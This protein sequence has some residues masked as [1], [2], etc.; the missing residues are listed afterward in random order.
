MFILY[1]KLRYNIYQIKI[2]LSLYKDEK[3]VV[4]DSFPCLFIKGWLV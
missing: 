1:N 4:T 3:A 2:Y